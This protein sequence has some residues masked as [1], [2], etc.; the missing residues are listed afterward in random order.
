[1][2]CWTGDWKLWVI[3]FW[4]RRKNKVSEAWPETPRGKTG[5]L[6]IGTS[7]VV[8]LAVWLVLEAQVSPER[9]SC[10]GGLSQGLVGGMVTH[11]F[12]KHLLGATQ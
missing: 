12:N 1:M 11:S 4:G 3:H 2:V 5:H 9:P 10:L 6:P 7:G 8:K